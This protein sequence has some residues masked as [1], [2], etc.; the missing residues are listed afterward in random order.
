[1]LLQKK[2]LIDFVFHLK[3]SFSK[4]LQVILTSINSEPDKP[5]Y[6]N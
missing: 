3:A 6:I 4:Q 1:M 2:F 5:L